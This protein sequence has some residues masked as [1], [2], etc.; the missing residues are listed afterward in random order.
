MRA[1]VGFGERAENGIYQ[2]MQ[3]HIG[4]RMA[5]HAARM[6]NANAGQR[7]VIPVGKSVDVETVAGPHVR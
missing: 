7:D 5:R 1:D 6:R 4:V 2:G 3:C